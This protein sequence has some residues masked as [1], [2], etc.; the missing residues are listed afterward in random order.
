MAVSLV[1]K[2]LK[3]QVVGGWERV[4]GKCCALLVVFTCPSVD[5]TKLCVFCKCAALLFEWSLSGEDAF[6]FG[7]GHGYLREV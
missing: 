3:P 7:C 6:R 1:Q 5:Q 4:L 2:A